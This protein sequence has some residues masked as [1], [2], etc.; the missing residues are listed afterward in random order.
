MQNQ[1]SPW[2]PGHRLRFERNCRGWDAAEVAERMRRLAVHLRQPDP[3]ITADL[4]GQWE[5][6]VKVGPA[7]LTLWC[8]VLEVPVR[9]AVALVDPLQ[10]PEWVI[11]EAGF[12]GSIGDWRDPLR[13]RDF[14]RVLAGM[15]TL[16]AVDPA[17]LDAAL[18]EPVQV[19]RGLVDDLSHYVVQLAGQWDSM[20]PVLHHRAVV[21]VL[22]TIKT[23]LAG[24]LPVGLRRDLM[25]VGGHAAT[26]TGAL[27]FRLGHED[28]A[29]V[30]LG[31][32]RK[33]AASAGDEGMEAFA[34]LLTADTLSGVQRGGDPVVKHGHVMSLLDHAEDLAAPSIPAAVRAHIFVRQ[35]E[36][37]AAAGDVAEAERYL[38]RA[39]TAVALGDDDGTR[40]GMPWYPS[41]AQPLFRGNVQVLAGEPAA[42]LAILDGLLAELPAESAYRRSV[43]VDMGA[44][45]AVAGDVDMAAAVLLVAVKLVD[46]A[47]NV[48]RRRRIVGVRQRHLER[49]SAEPAVRRLDE[50]LAAR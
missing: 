32:G 43:M 46:A 12:A 49:W 39:D 1:P 40:Y 24:P 19:D 31:L 48:D 34:V 30:Q 10:L 6:G 7:R 41:I 38:D 35:A 8:T 11:L 29:R 5:H 36:E 18:A 9:D 33:L 50:A 13:R 26:L 4:V 27:A 42:A 3:G 23:L 16:T 47:G 28:D 14:L 15:V 20:P 21:T 45:Y 25:A 22:E 44:A 37:H 17:R 2:E